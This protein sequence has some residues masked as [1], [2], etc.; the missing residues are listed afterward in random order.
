MLSGKTQRDNVNYIN[1]TYKD[2]LRFPIDVIKVKNYDTGD[3]KTGKYHWQYTATLKP[4]GNSKISENISTNSLEELDRRLAKKLVVEGEKNMSLYENIKSN[5]KESD[6]SIA[7]SLTNDRDIA[8]APGNI[9]ITGS[10]G[11][12]EAEEYIENLLRGSQS[13][14]DVANR[15]NSNTYPN[16]GD[17]RISGN[18]TP[19]KTEHDVIKNRYNMFTNKRTEI[20]YK[21]RSIVDNIDENGNHR[22]LEVYTN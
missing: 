3:Q 2:I 15:L 8:L 18:W 21:T 10:G 20:P 5:L 14:E 17:K 16:K 22:I 7:L 6:N 12:A 13:A 1:T 9:V 19:V 4:T 11:K